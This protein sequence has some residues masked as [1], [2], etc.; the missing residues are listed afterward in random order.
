[1]EGFGPA[2]RHQV[3]GGLPWRGM[4]WRNHVAWAA[5]WDLNAGITSSMHR[6]SCPFKSGETKRI[7]GMVQP[8]SMYDAILSMTA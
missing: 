8:A 6:W 4:G 3:F 7:T 2:R 1:M 5:T